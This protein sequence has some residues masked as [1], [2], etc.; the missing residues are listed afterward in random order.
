[1]TKN[2]T[3]VNCVLDRRRLLA[4]LGAAA[5]LFAE[6]RALAQDVKP[7]PRRREPFLTDSYLEQLTEQYRDQAQSD[8]PPR[9]LFIGNSITLGHNVP[10]RVAAEAASEGVKLEVALAAATG[11]RLRETARIEGLGPLLEASNWDVLVLQDHTTTPFR[12]LDRQSSHDTIAGLAAKARPKNVLLYPPWPRAP[13]HAF[14]SRAPQEEQD[15]PS[16]PE[17]FAQRT[18][19]FYGSIARKHGFAVAPVPEHW[20]N[21]VGQQR[22][23]YDS[24][25]YHASAEGADL[26]A[27][28]IWQ[29][30]KRLL[31][32]SSP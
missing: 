24:D 6:R 26:A 28:V 13:G 23:V 14:Y 18:M 9:V 30:L 32:G 31:G 1:M 19:D 16:G 20:L 22:P 3:T 25:K 27:S 21:A 10:A 5:V 17:D 12:A 7:M 4:G 8:G 29:S 2:K 15:L 11:A